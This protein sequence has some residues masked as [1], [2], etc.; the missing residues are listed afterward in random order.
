MLTNSPQVISL[1]Q[2]PEKS[3]FPEASNIVNGKNATDSLRNDRTIKRT[4]ITG[5]INTMFLLCGVP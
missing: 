2:Q 1:T 5:D 4:P 3:G